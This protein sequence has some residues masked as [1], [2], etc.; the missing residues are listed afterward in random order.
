MTSNLSM[1]TSGAAKAVHSGKE[2]TRLR[3]LFLIPLGIAI[4]AIIAA[5]TLALYQHEHQSI[6]KG[7]MKIR[8]SA[9]D[10]YEDSIHYDARAL[11]AV[12]D[13][14]KRDKELHEALKQADRQ[15]LLRYTATL[16]DELR[17]NY[18]I[19][20]FY[21]TGID[22]VNLLRVHTPQRFGDTINRI[23]TLNAEKSGTTAYGVELGPLGTFTL[24][25]V[26]PWYDPQTQELIGYVELG[27]EIDR[28]LQKLR[29]FFDVEVYVLIHKDFLERNKW[30]EGM[31]TLRRTP[32]W[33]R[34]PSVV[35]RPPTS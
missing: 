15:Q 9:Q 5:L 28:V 18:S 1:E 14:L 33:E 13:S 3:L 26:T 35:R 25:L 11:R 17:R 7:V 4:I 31:R 2:T 10:F 30:E 34:F 12:M 32:N 29:D 22:R 23:T 19:T 24:R 27:M 20:H 8:A 6:H 16:F 21:F